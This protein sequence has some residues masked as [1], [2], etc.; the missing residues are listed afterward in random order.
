MRNSLYKIDTIIEILQS[1]KE[2]LKIARKE[3]VIGQKRK[4]ELDELKK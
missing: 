1:F 4:K 3:I 2:H